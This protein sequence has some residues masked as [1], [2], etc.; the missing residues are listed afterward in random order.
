MRKELLHT[1]QNRLDLETEKIAFIEK[2]KFLEAEKE[3]VP[4][5]INLRFFP[6]LLSMSLT[7]Y[8]SQLEVE[9]SNVSQ[10]RNDLG[11]QLTNTQ[12]KKDVLNDELMRLRHRIEQVSE[13]NSRVNKHLEDLVK[14]CEEKQVNLT[15]KILLS[16]HTKNRRTSQSSDECDWKKLKILP[17]HS[18]ESCDVW[19]FIAWTDFGSFGIMILSFRNFL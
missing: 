8:F 17:A 19:C 2:C 13:T 11:E 5:R 7:Y 1:E 18:S 12:R 4:N 14:E 10:E 16:V 15:Y 9:L 3:K 6:V